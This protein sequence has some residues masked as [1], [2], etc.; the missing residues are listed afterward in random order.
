MN[1]T[2]KR[3]AQLIRELVKLTDEEMFD[4]EFIHLLLNQKLSLNPS[5]DK[6][7]TLGEKAADKVAR[8]AG[9]WAFIFSFVSCIVIWIIINLLMMADAFDQYPF[10]LL[11]LILS[12]VAAI[13]APLIMMSQNRQEAKDRERAENDFRVN[14]KSEAIIGDLHSKM[15]EVLKTQHR[16]IMEL[17]QLKKQDENSNT[18]FPN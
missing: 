5:D 8:F 12:C 3:R 13:Q 2:E 1:Q 9:S 4:E 14:L 18:K 10:I 17:E 16:I 7:M 15:E 6:N 11:N